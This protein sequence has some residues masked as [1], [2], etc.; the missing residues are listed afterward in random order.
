[1]RSK[2]LALGVVALLLS[3]ATASRAEEPPPVVLDEQ[4]V[5]VSRATAAGD[6]TGA[7]TVVEASRFLG[8]AKDVAQLVA[9]APGVA[10]ND[11]GGLGQLTTVSIRG[12]T[13][14]GVL[15]LLDGLPL[16][17]AF[18][19]AVDLSSIPRGWIERIEV[20]RGPEGAL[21]GAGALGGVVNVVTRRAAA[22]QWSAEG[23]AGSFGSRRCAADGAVAVL[24]GTLLLAASGDTTDGGFPYLY[25]RTR[26]VGADLGGAGA[27]ERRGHARRGA[28]APLDPGARRPPRHGA[29]GLGRASAACPAS[30]YQRP[31]IGPDDWQRDGRLL[32]TGPLRPWREPTA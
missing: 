14:D 19:G 18:G 24:G 15:V 27:R 32:L 7:A 10:V 31:P 8:E 6:P 30:P 11:Y 20:L 26:T 12:S 25:D 16:N 13:A 21:F 28:G 9:T 1:M 17:T 5:R 4:V 29:A 3:S 2:T 22:G 23:S